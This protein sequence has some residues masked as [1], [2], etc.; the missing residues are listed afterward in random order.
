MTAVIETVDLTRRFGRLDAVERLNLQ[1]PVG[2]LFAFVGPNGAGKTT[3][4]KVLL[5]LLRPTLGKAIVLGTD[6]RNIGPRE[7]ARIGTSPKI[8]IY[9]TG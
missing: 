7:L 2:S 9:P 5:N 1:V 4:I 6:S 8:R 3:T